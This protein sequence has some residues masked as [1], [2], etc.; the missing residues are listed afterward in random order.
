MV[1]SW[2]RPS[3]SRPEPPPS[4]VPIASMLPFQVTSSTGPVAIDAVVRLHRLGP[5]AQKS[6]VESG[7]RTLGPSR[8]G[9]GRGK[10]VTY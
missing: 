1:T 10:V 6:F 5:F 8:R 9:T 7:S 4:Q 2:P 3:E